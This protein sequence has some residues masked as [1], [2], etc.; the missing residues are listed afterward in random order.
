VARPR[1]VPLVL[2]EIGLVYW[3]DDSPVVTDRAPL[4]PPPAE[5][6]RLHRNRGNPEGGEKVAFSAADHDVA[7]DSM[8]PQP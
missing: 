4:N 8:A 2:A 5:P 3:H 7:S 1:D 6:E